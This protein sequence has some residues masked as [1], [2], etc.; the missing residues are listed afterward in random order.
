MKNTNSLF[1]KV[2]KENEGITNIDV[3]KIFIWY[4]LL[5]FSVSFQLL[6]IFSYLCNW[7]YAVT[8]FSCVFIILVDSIIKELLEKNPKNFKRLKGELPLVKLWV[9]PLIFIAIVISFSLILNKWL[10]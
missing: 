3:R 2:V 5:G 1:N 10:F 7:N 9:F 6:F 8:T 4:D